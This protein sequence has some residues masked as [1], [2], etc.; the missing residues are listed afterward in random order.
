MDI[1]G[2]T[3]KNVRSVLDPSKNTYFF[4][5]QFFLGYLG[6]IE[7]HWE[8]AEAQ[9]PNLWKSTIKK[10]GTQRVTP[11]KYSVHSKIHSNLDHFHLKNFDNLLNLDHFHL[12]FL[13]I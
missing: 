11:V 3:L 9:N 4:G 12:K 6:Q 2:Y 1:K 8:P 7:E 10:A 5:K 13:I